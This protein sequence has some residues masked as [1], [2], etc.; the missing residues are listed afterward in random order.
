MT[1]ARTRS[2]SHF[3][4]AFQGSHSPSFALEVLDYQ[5]TM[6]ANIR[7]KAGELTDLCLLLIVPGIISKLKA[8]WPDLAGCIIAIEQQSMLVCDISM[9]YV[10]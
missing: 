9:T 7:S 5:N 10:V 4:N 6:H 8:F 2:V 3:I 1:S